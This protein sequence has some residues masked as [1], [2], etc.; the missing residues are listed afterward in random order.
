[1]KP[2]TCACDMCRAMCAHSTC[3]CSPDDVKRIEA[4]G[5]GAHLTSY[6]IPAGRAV[7]VAPVGGG[8]GLTTT[9]GRPCSLFDGRD[10]A[11]HEQ[12]LKP[13]EG[14]LAHHSRHWLD[15]R[16]AVLATWGH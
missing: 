15:V 11:L 2:I 10:C 6:D 4:A 14:R 16:K 12:G 9:R 5:L 8:S 3:L 7:G 1:M 13:L